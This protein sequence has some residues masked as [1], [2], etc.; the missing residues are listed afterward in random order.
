MEE[1]EWR[2]GL[3]GLGIGASEACK[4]VYYHS[5]VV[6]DLDDTYRQFKRFG[7]LSRRETIIWRLFF[8]LAERKAVGHAA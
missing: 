7:R 2:S 5:G 8:I 4:L 1:Q 3:K 6:M